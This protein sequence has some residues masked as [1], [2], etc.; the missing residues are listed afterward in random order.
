MYRKIIF[1]LVVFTLF[2][3]GSCNNAPVGDLELNNGA[4]WQVNTEMMPPL[5]ASNQ[6]VANYAANGKKDY[7]A[8][9]EKLKANNKVLIS[10]C[11]MSGKSH[12]ELHKWLHPYMGL[13]AEL[14]SAQD[15]TQANQTLKKIE[16]SF[17]TFNQFFQ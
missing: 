10:S 3:L 16:A 6:L 7:K 13:V 12:D 11:T 9:A 2:F 14:E 4:K 1:Y 5:K 17:K 8:L 15:E